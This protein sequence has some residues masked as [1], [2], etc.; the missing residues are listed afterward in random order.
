MMRRLVPTATLALTVVLLAG[1]GFHLRGLNQPAL[2][3]PEIGL[4]AGDTPLA[5]AVQDALEGA[6]TRVTD[7]AD[8]RVNLGDERIQE[9]RLTRSDSGSRET[10]LTL[11]APFSVQRRDDDA[12]VLNQRQLETSTTVLIS[13]DNLY[14]MDQVRLEAEQNLRREAARQLVDRLEALQAP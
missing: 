3:L 11:T 2:S 1:C 4:T 5:Q 7:S 10:E 6:G 8:L 9:T 14:S 13:T 12:Y